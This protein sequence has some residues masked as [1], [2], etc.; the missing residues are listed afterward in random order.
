LA[1]QTSNVVVLR[2][3]HGFSAR[4]LRFAC[5]GGERGS[6]LNG[7]TTISSSERF[8]WTPKSQ[9]RHDFEAALCEGKIGY[10]ESGR[11]LRFYQDGLH[12]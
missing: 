8:Q 9:F 3:G 10:E 2:G 5:H 7:S 12:G 1:L 6:R 11:L 4:S